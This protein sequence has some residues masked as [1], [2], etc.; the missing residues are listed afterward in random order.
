MHPNINAL[1]SR[2]RICYRIGKAQSERKGAELSEKR[3]GKGLQKFFKV[4]VKE[5]KYSLKYLGASGF[6]A[7][8][9]IP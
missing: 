6:E 4:F 3:M 9:F 2:L 1:Y 5:L 8:H 7:S